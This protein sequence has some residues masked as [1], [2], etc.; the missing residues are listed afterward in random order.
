M[1]ANSNANALSKAMN[2]RETRSLL[3]RMNA[4][5]AQMIRISNNDPKL[6]MKM[7]KAG[8]LLENMRMKLRRAQN[9]AYRNYNMAKKR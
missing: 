9:K 1:H 5:K 7:N 8:L 6:M 4:I 2:T 3:S